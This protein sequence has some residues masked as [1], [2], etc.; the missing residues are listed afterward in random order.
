MHY[1]AQ[2]G[3][4]L[5]D[6][7]AYAIG[8]LCHYLGAIFTRDR[9]AGP[10]TLLIHD[11]LRRLATRFV[12]LVARVE[13]G[14]LR[15]ARVRVAPRAARVAAPRVMPGGF[16]WLL[17]LMPE[18]SFYSEYLEREV[19]AD[20]GFAALL[21][22]AA[23]AGRLARSVLWMMGRPAPEAVR[24][25]ARPKRQRKRRPGPPPIAYIPYIKQ[26]YKSR[27]PR[28]VWPSEADLKRAGRQLA[29]EAWLK[30]LGDKASGK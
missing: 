20:P 27:Y 5:L 2:P 8:G 22:A 12:A 18:G 3:P 13:A 21:A 15:P 24:L 26:P 29:R 10:L 25:P 17:K 6:R 4:T 14:T 19:L 1:L 28:S 7:F 16:G 30:T 23:Q 9:A 11:R